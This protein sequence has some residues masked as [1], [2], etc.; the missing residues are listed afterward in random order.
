MQLSLTIDGIKQDLVG[1]ADL[2]DETVRQAAERMASAL[3]PT[4]TVRLLEM[5]S[6]L[7]AEISD[8]M[9]ASRVELRVA[10]DEAHLVVVEDEAPAP[11]ADEGDLSARITLRVSEQL[12]QLVESAATIDG[13][14]TNAWVQRALARATAAAAQAP[15]RSGKRISG[16]GRT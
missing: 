1:L 15:H 8:Q 5:L 2:G 10:G 12:K 9:Q 11:H 13:A 3:G 7:A 6:Q 16:Y 4:L 14:S